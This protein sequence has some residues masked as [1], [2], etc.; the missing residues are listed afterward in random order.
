MG[1]LFVYIWN[2]LI[3]PKYELIAYQTMHTMMLL[4]I[5]V[6]YTYMYIIIHDYKSTLYTPG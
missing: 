3:H 2:T 6:Y 5:L 4:H 1:I